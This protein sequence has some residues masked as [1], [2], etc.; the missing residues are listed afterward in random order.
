VDFTSGAWTHLAEDMTMTTIAAS[1]PPSSYADDQGFFLR[2][3]VALSVATVLCFVQIAARGLTDPLTAPAWVHVHA[4][5]MVGWLA[6]F[7]TQNRLAAN[8]VRLHRKLGVAGGAL[9]C[10]ML[11]M[12]WFIAFA[13]LVVHRLPPGSNASFFFATTTAEIMVFAGLIVWA[14]VLRR[15]P[16]WH[17]RLMFGATIMA[18]GGPGFSRLLPDPLPVQPVSAWIYLAVDVALLGI[19][20]RHDRRTRGFVHPATL[21]SAATIAAAQALVYAASYDRTLAAITDAIARL[22]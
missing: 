8:N 3:S 7:V 1:S 18:C 22:T 5:L 4:L 21:W 2:Y 13:T 12:G 15:D 16:E 17:R 14:L 19:I 20:M 10:A 9:A 6:L 11:A